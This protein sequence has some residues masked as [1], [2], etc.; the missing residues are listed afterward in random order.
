MM[1]GKKYNKYRLE[2]LG[3]TVLE[4][5]DDIWNPSL[6]I[7]SSDGSFMRYNIHNNVVIDESLVDIAIDRFIVQLRREK[8][9]KLNEQ[10]N[11]T[12]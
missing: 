12:C 2:E 8:I 1:Y 10:F 4:D 11:R 6:I 3:I 9:Q 7:E 5:E